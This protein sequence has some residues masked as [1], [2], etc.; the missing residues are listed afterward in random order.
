MEKDE[1]RN[2]LLDIKADYLEKN[3][4]RIEKIKP[5]WDSVQGRVPDILNI[6]PKIEFCE[7][8][9][10]RDLW[11]YGRN[12]IWSASYTGDVGRRLRWVILD[13][14]TGY[15]IGICGLSSSLSIPLFDQHIGWTREMKWKN[16][17]VNHVMTMSHCAGMPELSKYLTGKLS[18]LSCR[19]AEV[20]NAFESKYGLKAVTFFTTSLYGKSSL[21]NRL[22][23]YEYLGLTK[24]SSAALVPME[25]KQQMREDF[26]Q[27]KGKHSETYYNE[28]GSVRYVYGVV[29][30]YQK[31]NKYANTQDEANQRGVYLIPLADNY[32]EFL[33]GTTNELQ[34]FNHKTFAELTEHWK[35]RWMIPRVERLKTGAV[36]E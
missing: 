14:N 12:V 9:E 26:K 25:V 34:P 2:K 32:K 29:K 5:V 28:D 36:S 13:K 21:Y 4:E 16:K 8:Q 19:S 1:L 20:V 11:W 23:G 6:E 7:T 10:L 17:K 33:C 22:E 18:A 15:I 3:K 35:T 27:E 30:T 31:L 24:G